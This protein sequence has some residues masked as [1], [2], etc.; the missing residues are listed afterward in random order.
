MM[1][2]CRSGTYPYQSLGRPPGVT[3]SS[4]ASSTLNQGDDGYAACCPSLDGQDCPVP[5]E[6]GRV[7]DQ[8][9]MIGAKQRNQTRLRSSN[10][11]WNDWSQSQKVNESS[12]RI[13]DD[14]PFAPRLE[15]PQE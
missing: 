12:S 2:V 11:Y 13:G 4:R 7:Y 1:L 8:N 3:P 5:S 6:V 9:A 14:R 10:S 15:Q